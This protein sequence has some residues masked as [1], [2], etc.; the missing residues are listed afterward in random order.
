[1]DFALAALL[2]ALALYGYRARPHSAVNRWFALQTLTLALWII[3]VAG[4]HTS[5]HTEFWGRWT[6]ASACL[7]PP[8]FF[9]FTC[10]FPE[11]SHPRPVRALPFVIIVALS[12]ATLSAFTPLIAHT[13]VI[14]PAG[15]LRRQAGPLMPLFSLYF[16]L[17]T[18]S[19]LGLL[20][21][22]W[23]RATGQTRAQ[24]RF[25]NTG[26]LTLCVGAITTNLLLP[27]LTGHS[28]YST[29][30]PYFV[31]PLVG[32]IGHAIIRHR[33]FDLRLM[34]HRG[35]A[36]VIFI[37]LVSASIVLILKQMGLDEA[38]DL[39]APP[40]EGLVVLIVASVSLSVP[41]AP[42]LARLMDNYF[43]RARPDLD[44]ALH[45]AAR[46]LS[47]LLVTTEIAAEIAAILKSTLAVDVVTVTT[48]PLIR[49]NVPAAVHEAAWAIA[50][51]PPAVLLLAREPAASA[52]VT[53]AELLRNNG[54][55]V[56]VALGRGAQKM[57]VILLGCRNGGEAY[58][59]S[60]L[61]FIERLAELSS[62]ALEV[63]FLYGHQVTLEGERHQLEHFARMGRAYAGL[64]H[65]IR[66]PLTT[67]SN[68]VSLIPDRLDDSEF[69]DV[70]TRLIPGEVE[71]IVKLTERLRLMAPADSAHFG[72]VDLR[73]LLAGIASIQSVSRN[74][75][76]ILLDAP[77]DLPA[78]RGDESQLTQLFMNLV[79]NAVDAMPDGGALGLR[80]QASNNA[81]G[82]LVLTAYVIDDGPGIPKDIADRVFEPFF[83]TKPSGTGLGLSICREIAGFHS[84][85]LRIFS[86]DDR[87]GTIAAV[88]FSL[89]PKRQATLSDSEAPVSILSGASLNQ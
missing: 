46:K 38:V 5:H 13:F 18:L 66:T 78:I 32:L 48:S 47:R 6:F 52:T 26:L 64:G 33:L 51:P 14:I 10:M 58:W 60:T 68:L 28:K 86:R 41:V 82:H 70:L 62:M 43:L 89:A 63:A 54:F 30:G 76:K 57:G 49:H 16:L 40:F 37:G 23:R 3:G 31:L 81:Q 2:I 8:A 75:I 9:G 39:I 73:Q 21:F 4:T 19:I 61:E 12:F 85:T 53:H 45:Q 77:G 84:A 55:E 88:E 15:G 87:I 7:M 34:I 74:H 20:I 24:L 29:L 1:M 72:P 25:Y 42:H 56:W 83:T 65:E 80:L 59:G 27:T 79:N 36:F 71:R 44:Y 35:A 22:K 50:I 67:I 11:N 69:R 17:S